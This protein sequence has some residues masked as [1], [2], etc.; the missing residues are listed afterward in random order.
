MREPREVLSAVTL[1]ALALLLTGCG[2]GTSTADDEPGT[3]PSH[4]AEAGRCDAVTAAQLSEWAGEPF[5]VT[6]DG[7]DGCQSVGEVESSLRIT[8]TF[9]ERVGTLRADAEHEAGVGEA[10][11]AVEVGG[12]RA[13][14]ATGAPGG[15]P[16]ALVV[17]PVGGEDAEVVAVTATNNAGRAPVEPSR[18]L[19]VASQVAA[20]YVG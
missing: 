17:A 9:K 8:W 18:L 1:S 7:D 15:E 20:A 19:E 14:A 4:S 5:D 10:P 13:Y 11:R 12:V 16:Q 2:S 6:D 3:P